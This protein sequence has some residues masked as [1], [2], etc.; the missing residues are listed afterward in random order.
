MV[1]RIVARLVPVGEGLVGSLDGHADVVGLLLGEDGELGAEGSEV[2]AGD[3]LVE[4]LGE[5]VDVA[6][7][8]LAGVLLL[9]ELELGEGLVGE[10]GG[11]DEGGVAGGAAEVEE[12]ALGE[13]DDGLAVGEDELVD[14]GLD[15]VAGGDLHE[16]VH[17]NLVVEVADV[18]NDGVVLH[19]GHHVGH[20]DAL[21]AG[22]GDED[23]GG[24]NDILEGNDGEALHARLKGADGVDL[25]DEDNSSLGAHG[26]GASLSD[27]A[28][29]ADDGLLSGDHDVSGA[30][31]SVGEG[32][33]AAVEVVELGLGDGVVDVDGG[34]EEVALLLHGVEAV[35]AGGGLL[36]DAHA[37]DG[38]LVPLVRDAG[39]EEALDDGED[40]L[41]LGVVGGGRV[42]EGSILGEGVLGL[43][44]LVDEEGHVASVVDDEVGSVSLA[45]VGGPGD[46]GEGALPVLLEGLSLPREDGSGLVAGDGGGGVV[47]GGEDVAG[48]P[49]HVA[50]EGL[51]GLD[52]HG[53]LD[54]H[55]EGTGD[56]GAL[57]GL[58]RAELLAGGHEA[59]HLD[60]GDLD[61]L[62]AEVGEGD[63]G[64]LVVSSRH[65]N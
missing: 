57:E 3:L 10:R 9:P 45:V 40:D 51:E 34:E 61:L 8:V 63:V 38:E 54:G 56:T 27:V 1:R 41:E 6:A 22:G 19:L 44:S 13:D 35:D 20:E 14:L 47:L 26:M 55:V 33:L 16:S 28:E 18:S 7:G 39:L 62:A 37:A 29:A 24:G 43:L 4:E 25:G 53:G 52:E 30:H 58:G 31:K 23:V 32:V 21:V 48:A 42:G 59:G 60:L 49:A 65:I 36:G 15:V 17:V 64:N 46:G 50:S 5:D 12:A 2:E 11:H